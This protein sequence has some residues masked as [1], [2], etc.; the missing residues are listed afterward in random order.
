MSNKADAWSAIISTN[1]LRIYILGSP[2]M[3]NLIKP[4]TNT[5]DMSRSGLRSHNE[6]LTTQH[7]APIYRGRQV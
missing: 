5:V 2:L 3:Q 7:L 4:A 1:C 6:R